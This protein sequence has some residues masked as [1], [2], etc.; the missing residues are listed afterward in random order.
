M[1]ANTDNDMTVA[2]IIP[3]YKVRSHIMEVIQR[4]E[5]SV[6]RIYVVDD[7]CPDGSGK[8]VEQ[9]C[10]DDRVKV[11]FHNKNMGVGG[12]VITGYREALADG[13]DI[14]V[15]VDGDGQMDPSLIPN[16]VTPIK[17][18]LADYTKGNRFYS[19]S[20]VRSMPKL[21]LI[22]N[23]GLSFITKFSSGYWGIFDPTNG[24]TAIHRTALLRLDLACISKRYFFETD[25]LVKL[26]LERA[27]VVD[28]PMS[29]VYGEEQSGLSITKI[30]PEFLAKHAYESIRRLAYTYY[31][32]DFNLASLS[33]ALGSLL[34]VFGFIF[35][36]AAWSHSVIS[37]QVASTGT[38]MLS[39]LPIILGTQL[40]LNFLGF[41]ISNQPRI[42]LILLSQLSCRA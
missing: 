14:M 10:I 9:N 33:L 28:I 8:Y 11:I 18:A 37:G 21:R 26:G 31:V 12:A 5:P 30:I 39:A 41:D 23:A 36:I 1:K 38:V 17:E 42:P 35:G 16:F 40:I 4:I 32:R 22:G 3:C 6:K 19:Y 34:F 15:K 27:V 25:M 20:Y 29:A 24:Y 13:I 7:A 2:V